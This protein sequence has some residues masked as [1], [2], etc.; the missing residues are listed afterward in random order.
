LENELAATR[1]LAA[2]FGSFRQYVFPQL[3]PSASEVTPAFYLRH[4]EVLDDFL[5]RLQLVLVL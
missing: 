2:A 1:A 4:M 5:T 3:G